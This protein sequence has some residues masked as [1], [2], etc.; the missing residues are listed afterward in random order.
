MF[1]GLPSICYSYDDVEREIIVLKKGV[2]GYFPLKEDVKDLYECADYNKL[3]EKMGVTKAQERAMKAGSM[4]G[5][6]C[7]ASNPAN[8]NEDGT[9]KRD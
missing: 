3:N 1:D 7:P 9:L 6:D 2:E 8:Y 5:W 4:F